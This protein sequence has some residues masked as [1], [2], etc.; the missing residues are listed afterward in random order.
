[1]WGKLDA[2]ERL[3]SIILPKDLPECRV[4]RKEVVEEIHESILRTE[5]IIKP[6]F[7]R[8]ENRNSLSI[9]RPYVEFVRTKYNIDRELPEEST[10]K[11]MARSLG[12]G[13]KILKPSESGVPIKIVADLVIL[14]QQ[15]VIR[16]N[17]PQL[18]GF[19]DY[20]N[21][22]NQ[23]R[24]SHSYETTLPYLEKIKSNRWLKNLD[25]LITLAQRG[26]KEF[27]KETFKF[28]YFRVL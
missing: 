22:I 3:V 6:A 2:A 24:A 28:I 19:P 1:M 18:P 7:E 12:V 9:E 10:L 21:I 17:P 14:L 13:S 4:I 25:W 16:I 15:I 27:T 20:N 11:E 23:I 8:Q 5:S 26:D